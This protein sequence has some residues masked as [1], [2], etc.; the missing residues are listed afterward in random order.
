MRY[1]FDFGEDSVGG[2]ELLGGKG[3][4]LAMDRKDR[5]DRIDPPAVDFS[6]LD[7]PLGE[8]LSTQRSI[9]RLRPD[10]RWPLFKERTWSDQGDPIARSPWTPIGDHPSLPGF[11]G[12]YH[13]LL[14]HWIEL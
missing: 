14:Q 4:G 8:A 10:M 2:R 1:V 6:R 3:I 7:M 11:V 12:H 9:R 13:K 5:K